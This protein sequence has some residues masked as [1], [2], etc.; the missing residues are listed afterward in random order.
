V[1]LVHVRAFPGDVHI[2]D[3]AEHQGDGG[4]KMMTVFRAPLK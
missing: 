3:L 2:C 1:D 4:G